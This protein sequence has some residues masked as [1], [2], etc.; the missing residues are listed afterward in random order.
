VSSAAQKRQRIHD[1]WWE[2]KLRRH[3]KILI[4]AIMSNTYVAVLGARQRGKTLA[5]AYASQML[6]QGVRW[7]TSEGRK[8]TV[9]L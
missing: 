4:D 1:I 2:K 6:A 7:N 3:Q 8:V 9:P 5:I